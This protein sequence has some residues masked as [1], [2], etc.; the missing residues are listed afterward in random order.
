MV[1]KKPQ[2]IGLA[3]KITLNF[4]GMIMVLGIFVVGVVYQLTGRAL[5]AQVHQRA[6]AIAT[7]LSDASSGHVLAKNILDL[8]VLVSKYAR[9]E[10]TAYAFIQDS[11]GQIV[12]HSLGSFP[13]ELRE[14]LTSDQR[15]Q[16]GRRV[17]SLR[18]KTV[19]E[20]RTPILE[21][22]VGAAHIGIWGEGITA[23]IYG[24]LLPILA[25][26]G[27]GLL[28]AVVFSVFIAQG[29]IRPIR[30]LTDMAGR[31]SIGNL[32]TPFEIESRDEI[33]ELARSLERMR[34]SLKAAMSRL[35]A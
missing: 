9:L 21:G 11:K 33:G 25:L 22:Q 8:H 10:G 1:T 16:V 3:W 7:N 26:I 32:E 12:A 17:V 5:R 19:Y 24:A 14:T 28:A 6:L 27:M 20:T 30:R 15:R 13:E 31:M 4:V 29:I 23:E 35:S 18:G 34:A 2:G